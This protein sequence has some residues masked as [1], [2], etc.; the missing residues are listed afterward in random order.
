MFEVEPASQ[1]VLG[2]LT[3]ICF[4]FLLQKGQVAKYQ[5]VLGQ[6]LLADFT[7][8]K[9]MLTAIVTGA[10]GVYFLIEIGASKLDIWPFQPAAMIIGALFFGVGL[11]I[12][13]YC[14]GTGM[15]GAGE[16]ARDAMAGVGGMVFGAGI[17]VAGFNWLEAIALGLGDWGKLTIP[18][19]IG[20]RPWPI[21]MAL[22]LGTAVLVGMI[23]KLE[24]RASA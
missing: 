16:G 2:L 19:V 11:A 3:G 12:I 8:L 13:G 7:V 21:L 24:S 1:L 14:P 22:A 20:T 5:T 23:R 4:G 6:L 10:V 17:L 9:I 15:A 18:Q